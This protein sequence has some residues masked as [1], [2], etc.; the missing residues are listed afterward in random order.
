MIMLIFFVKQ[1]YIRGTGSL[2]V[3][4]YIVQKIKA[5]GVLSR[6]T[7]FAC[8]EVVRPNPARVQG[9]S[10][11]IFLS[12]I[13]TCF[14]KLFYFFYNRPDLISLPVNS[15]FR[16]ATTHIYICTKTNRRQGKVV[17]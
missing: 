15:N 4:T 16:S 17:F 8:V 3:S 9:G 13:C 1:K 12:Y 6:G 14:I 10:F 2:S 7:V 5:L 11:F